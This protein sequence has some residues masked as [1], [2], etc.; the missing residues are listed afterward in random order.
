MQR[1]GFVTALFSVSLLLVALSG[2][3]SGGSGKKV[4]GSVT[5]DGAPLADAKLVF[6]GQGGKVTTT[7]KDGKF[8]FE[9]TTPFN[10][11]KAGKYKV[12][13]EKWVSKDGKPIEP[14]MI[15]QERS[16]GTAKNLVPAKYG[17]LDSPAVINVD[18]KEPPHDLPVI[19]L[20][21]K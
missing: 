20:K 18:V 15:E 19:E 3:T 9:G 7:D 12:L 2:C 17:M 6:E 5:L 14:E 21:S 13:I 16:A 10:S 8:E 4:K 1:L 11:L